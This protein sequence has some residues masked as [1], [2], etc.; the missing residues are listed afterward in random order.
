[1][2]LKL[3]EMGD[4]SNAETL[5]DVLGNINA[6]G[7]EGSG[8]SEQEVKEQIRSDN[9]KLLKHYE[10]KYLLYLAA[11]NSNSSKVIPN[12]RTKFLQQAVIDDFNGL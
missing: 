10:D 12:S 6:L 2:K 7:L 3:L 11:R 5:L 1:V 4:H 9:E 8:Q